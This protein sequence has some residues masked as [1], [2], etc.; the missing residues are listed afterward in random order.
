MEGGKTQGKSKE[1]IELLMKRSIYIHYKL[2]GILTSCG[3][4]GNQA[5]VELSLTWYT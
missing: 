2:L 4:E 1:F 5:T 3:W